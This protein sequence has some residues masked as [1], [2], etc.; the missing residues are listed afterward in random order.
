MSRKVAKLVCFGRG[1]HTIDFGRYEWAPG[2]TA[3]CTLSGYCSPDKPP[4][5]N[6]EDVIPD[7]CPVVDKLPAIET[8]A[9]YAWVFKGPMVDVD[10]LDGDC[11]ECPQPSE[12][13]AGAMAG[14][15]YGSLLAVHE[16]TRQ[17]QKRGA[18]DHVSIREYIDGWRE[19]GARIGRYESGRIVWES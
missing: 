17:T 8:A 6:W 16:I 5:S 12:L 14:N 1:G 18:L 15:S 4:Q 19:H 11:S 9:G 7:G 3:T 2:H 13:F 10:L